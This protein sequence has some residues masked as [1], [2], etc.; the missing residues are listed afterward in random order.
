[1]GLDC[2]TSPLTTTC[3]LSPKAI[4]THPH[5][6]QS[7]QISSEEEEH[8]MECNGNEGDIQ[9]AINRYIVKKYY[10]TYPLEVALTTHCTGSIRV[11]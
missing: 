5:S 1:M 7:V 10:N 4:F 3:L 8:Q 9:C 2:D 11:L 6:R